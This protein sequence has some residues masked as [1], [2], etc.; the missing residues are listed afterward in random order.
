MPLSSRLAQLLL[1]GMDLGT[2]SEQL[3]VT[4]GTARFMLKG[5]FN[6]TACHRQSQLIRLLSLLP[7]DGR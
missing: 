7:G 3:R 1:E 2:A 4:A 6:K 5:I